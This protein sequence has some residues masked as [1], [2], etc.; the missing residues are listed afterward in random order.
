MKRSWWLNAVLAA[1]V[2]ALGAF[3]FLRPH[4]EIDYRLSELSAAEVTR[5]RLGLSGQPEIV[6]ERRQSDWQMTAPLAARVDAAQVQRFLAVLGAKSRERYPATGLARFDLSEPYARLSLN[7]AVLGFGG[8]NEM[9]REQ[10]VMSGDYVYPVE[11]RYGAALPKEPLQIASRQLFGAGEAP[12]TLELSDFTIGENDGR[13]ESKPAWICDGDCASWLAAWRLA[14][15]TRVA[16]APAKKPLATVR[17]RCKNGNDVTLSILQREPEFV[18]ARSDAKLAY[19]F[20]TDAG[21]RLLA[22]PARKDE[23]AK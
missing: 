8:V 7:D 11:L 13:F 16:P 15:A 21:R 22:P 17:A 9:T 4:G 18:L 2:A 23:K 12:V 20:P 5:I 1:M 19:F 3:V 14:T 6:L 10:Y